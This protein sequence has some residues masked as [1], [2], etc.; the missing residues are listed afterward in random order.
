MGYPHAGAWKDELMPS[1]TLTTTVVMT[2]VVLALSAPVAA[3]GQ[4]ATDGVPLPAVIV[5]A[6]SAVQTAIR[7]RRACRV[8]E[9]REPLIADRASAGPGA[10]PG[11]ARPCT[12]I[13]SAPIDAGPHDAREEACR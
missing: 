1:T 3:P 4:Q 10:G 11:N 8:R 9:K 6:A 13:R 7:A 12:P 2:P 5:P